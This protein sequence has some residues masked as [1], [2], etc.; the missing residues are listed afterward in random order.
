M[1]SEKSVSE[2]GPSG[3]TSLPP[4]GSACLYIETTQKK[5]Q[6]MKM[7]SLLLNDLTLSKGLIFFLLKPVFNLANDSIRSMV[8]FRLQLLLPEGQW[9]KRQWK[10]I[11]IK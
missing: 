9:E 11:R 5:F 10:K 8:R 1:K 4:I 7:F 2:T 6:V 3:A